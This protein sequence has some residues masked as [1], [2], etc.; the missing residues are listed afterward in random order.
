M[1]KRLLLHLTLAS[2]LM[3]PAGLAAAQSNSD[4][5]Q[6]FSGPTTT[7]SGALPGF[8]T[9]SALPVQP[10]AAVPPAPMLTPLAVETPP[11]PIVIELF[12]SEA[13]ASCSPANDYL[14][15]LAKRHNLLP[16]TFHVDYWDYTGWKD[17][18]ADPAFAERQRNYA[19]A[20]GKTMMYTPQVVVAGAIETLGSDKKAVEKALKAANRRNRMYALTLA[21]DASG[22]I[23]LGLP[24]A[25][26]SVP[27]SLWLVTYTYED[28]TD[29]SGG[30]NRGQRMI[31]TNVVHTLRKV[32]TWDGR[33]DDRLIKL[34]AAE[35]AAKP[36]AC[37]IIANE[38]E[39][40]PVVAAT[41]WDF[42]DLW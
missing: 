12:T 41:G 1:M 36:D 14:R 24:Q 34:N 7:P 23:H 31:T 13:C 38:A 29:I 2:L 33:P 8:G 6:P 20:Q 16:L 4:L 30:E 10:E 28:A 17:R 5:I 37:A 9:P 39:F 3:L 32:G 26:L 35:I 22:G 15:Q 21:K 19:A 42:K 40:G 27:A 18:F 25:A 11:A